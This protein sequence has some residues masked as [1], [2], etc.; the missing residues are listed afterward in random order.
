MAES[1]TGRLVVRPETSGTVVG[2]AFSTPIDLPTG[3]AKSTLLNIQAR[4]FPDQIRVELL[5]DEGIVR[6]AREAGL[7][8]LGPQ[9]QLYAVVTGANTAPPNLSGVHIGGFKAE[10]ALWASHDIPENGASLGSLDMMM[11]VNIDGESLSSGQRR[12]LLHWVEGGGHLIVSGGPSALSTAGALSALLPLAPEGSQSIDDLSALARFAGAKSSLSQRTII[13]VGGRHE[14]AESLVEQDGLPLLLRREIGAGLVDF[15][16]ADPTLEPLASWDK[17]E[18]LWLKLLATRAPHP[19]WRDGFTR[20]S[21]GADAIANLPGVD[22]L[23]P[24]Q[25]LCLFLVSYIALDWSAELFPVVAAAAQRLGL[26]HHTRCH[27]L[28][29]RHRLDGRFQSAR[30][31]DHRQPHDGGAVFRRSG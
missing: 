28:L 11:L 31:R 21:W 25:T 14:D 23:P 9:N 15:L 12:A 17:L 7:I 20:P 29:H 2:N 24:L 10:Q 4:S 19:T 13:A 18:D 3:A 6:A 5:D 26:V 27:H 16:A 8:D 1:V 30:R 22:L